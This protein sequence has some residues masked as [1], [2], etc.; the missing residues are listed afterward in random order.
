M[1]T[2]LAIVSSPIPPSPPSIVVC[3]MF[4][5]NSAAKN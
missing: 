3:P 4:F 1:A 2:V 5:I